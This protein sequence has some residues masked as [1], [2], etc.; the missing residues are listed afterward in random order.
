M[1]EENPLVSIIV[2]TKDRPK[3]LKKALES[4][5]SQTY[6][7]MEVVLVNDG[8]C[9][10]DIEEL[11]SILGDVSLNYIRLEKNKG[12]AHAG[13]VGMENANKGEY[14]GFLDD[15]DRFYSDHISILV[16]L[17]EK[18]DYKFAYADAN[19]AYIEFDPES[20][21][22]ITTEKKVFSSQDFSYNDL[23]VDN[24]IPL[25]CALFSKDILS[26][27]QG[28]DERFDIYEDWDLLIRIAEKYPFY[29][30]KKTTVEYVQW[31]STL[32]IA[33]T[34]EFAEKARVAHGQIINKHKEKFTADVIRVLVQNRRELPEREAI[35]AN[36]EKA[37]QERERTLADLEGL[38]ASLERTL[39]EREDTLDRIYSS[40]GW[41]CLLFYYRVRDDLLPHNSKRRV[42]VKAIIKAVTNP[43]KKIKGQVS[44]FDKLN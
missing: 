14:I 35:I 43:L 22:I 27:V 6:R 11:K 21:E 36:I 7:P 18:Y 9:D 25:I 15:D 37:L 29:H 42:F 17:L 38:K 5:A 23:I 16:S 41:K 13:N 2:R 31:S 8:G 24:Y 1:S 44:T 34:S 3:L 19:I 28:F 40:R 26:V 33:Q 4:I 10:L 20:K 30:V 39:K 12:R 32:Q